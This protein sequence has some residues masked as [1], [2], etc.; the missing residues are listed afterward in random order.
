[1]PAV[2]GLYIIGIRDALSQPR[3]DGG[4]ALRGD[5][6]EDPANAIE[7]RVRGLIGFL[8]NEAESDT[9]AVRDDPGCDPR[10]AQSEAL[11]AWPPTFS[12]AFPVGHGA[13]IV[14]CFVSNTRHTKE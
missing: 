8:I 2:S 7:V 5:R 12:L 6:I 10:N 13:A 3:A 4:V 14:Y 11:L 9:F 1:M